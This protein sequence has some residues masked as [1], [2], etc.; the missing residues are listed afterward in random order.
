M[1]KR[2]SDDDVRAGLARTAKRLMR[3]H[4]LSYEQAYER[5]RAAYVDA[6]KKKG[7]L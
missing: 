3:Q 1:P 6:M 7:K 4:G 2:P 5:A